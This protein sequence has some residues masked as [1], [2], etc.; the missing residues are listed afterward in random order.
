MI[1]LP[2]LH[3][4]FILIFLLSYPFEVV[5]DSVVFR[6]VSTIF[7]VLEHDLQIVLA[8][9]MQKIS[10]CVFCLLI[11]ELPNPKDFFS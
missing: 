6:T 1:F 7:F 11:P 3:I 8:T 5:T 2:D 4:P 9:S 10:G